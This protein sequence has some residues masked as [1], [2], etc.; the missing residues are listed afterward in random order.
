MIKEEKRRKMD[1]IMQVA[2]FLF[3]ELP[4]FLSFFFFFYDKKK[5]WG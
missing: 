5:R 4:E 3:G 1:D 2:F